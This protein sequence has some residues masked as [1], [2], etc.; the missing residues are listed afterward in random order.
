M[1]KFSLALIPSLLTLI[2]TAPSRADDT[3][4]PPDKSMYTIFNPV[5]DDLMRSFSTDRPTKSDS[6]YTVDAGHFQ[7]ETDIVNWTHD[8]Y[9]ASQTST[10]NLLILDPT[11]KVGLTQNSDLEVAFSPVNLNMSHNRVSGEN[12]TAA[13]FGDFY[14]RVKFNLLGNESGDYALAI[15]PY[16]KA[17]TAAHNLG[18]NHWEGGAYAPFQVYLPSDWTMS[19]TSEMDILE[20]AALNGYHTN[21]SNLINFGHPL[22]DE[23]VTGYVELWSDVNN[24]IGAQTQYTADFAVTWLVEENV[25]LDAG[26]NVGLN[27]AAPDLQPYFGLSQRF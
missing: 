24:D 2:A 13:G 3:T 12:A 11:L 14:T 4:P 17:P 10:N 22:F 21:F 15:V 20:N 16:I 5:P 7:Y 27:K 19:I 9:N 6:P 1:N 18:N 26:L 8:H 23:S 25:Q